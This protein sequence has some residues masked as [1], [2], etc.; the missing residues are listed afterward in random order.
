MMALGNRLVDGTDPIESD[1]YVGVPLLI[2][3]GILGLGGLAV[4]P[5]RS[6]QWCSFFSLHSSPS[7]PT[8]PS[9]VT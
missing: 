9:M 7:D 5:A 4:V 6:W 2:L 3:A 1:G 8:W